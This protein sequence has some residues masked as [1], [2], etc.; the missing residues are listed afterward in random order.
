M[1]HIEKVEGAVKIHVHVRRRLREVVGTI[2]RR[3]TGKADN[4]R[5]REGSRAFSRARG[6]M[7]PLDLRDR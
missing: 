6:L 1:V 5:R 4:P 2:E 3:D 7:S